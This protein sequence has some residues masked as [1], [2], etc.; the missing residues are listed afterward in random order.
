M[1]AEEGQANQG[2]INLAIKMCK[3][4]AAAGADGIEFQ[5]FLADDMYI[6]KDP[7]HAT[8]QSKELAMEQIR[9]LITAAHGEGLIVQVAG[10][11]PRIVELC[12][13]AREWL[14]D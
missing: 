10:L 11:S 1:F 2:D 7:G 12:A 4:A 6:R 8:Y 5:F 9:D 3:K 14:N 13:K